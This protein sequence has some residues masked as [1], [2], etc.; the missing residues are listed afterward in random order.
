MGGERG[1]LRENQFKRGVHN[2]NASPEPALAHPLGLL[3]PLLQFLFL[4]ADF[5]AENFEA[6]ILL[7]RTIPRTIRKV[8]NDW[9]GTKG[10][11]MAGWVYTHG[12][13]H[14]VPCY[15]CLPWPLTLESMEAME[16]TP[17]NEFSA[18][19]AL[20]DCRC[21]YRYCCCFR[22]R[23]YRRQ[24]CCRVLRCRVPDPGGSLHPL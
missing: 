10:F 6:Q 1:C 14:L 12:G 15:H 4:R 18:R 16:S 19:V 24:H 21:S 7:N 20:E 5:C 13:P 23:C 22:L 3:L 8:G 9:R 2:A 17:G 11:S